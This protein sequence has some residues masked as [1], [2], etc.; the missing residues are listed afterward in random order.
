MQNECDIDN[1]VANLKK[2]PETYNTITGICGNTTQHV[3]LKRKLNRLYEDGDVYKLVIPGTR[4]GKVLYYTEPKEYKILVE[5]KG[6]RGS[7]T[8]YF[9]KYKKIGPKIIEVEKCWKL[10]NSI[11]EAQGRKEFSEFSVLLFL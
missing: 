3:I 8:Y 10:G 11:W 1:I 5:A 6:I 9:N 7:E 4:C 2:R